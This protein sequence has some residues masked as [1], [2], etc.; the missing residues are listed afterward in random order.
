MENPFS[1]LTRYRSA[2]RK[3]GLLL[4]ALALAA[5]CALFSP[6]NGQSVQAMVKNQPFPY[7]QG[8]AMDTVLYQS[9]KAKLSAAETLKT[10]SAQTIKALQNEITAT[11]KALIDQQKLGQH[12]AKTADSLRTVL[13]D[14]GTKFKTASEGLQSAQQ[15]TDEVLKVLPRSIRKIVQNQS[16]DQQAE[17]VVDFI[18]VLKARK[19][20]W[21]GAGSG[22]AFVLTLIFAR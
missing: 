11:A 3:A 8:V 5:L 4:I 21:L 1:S 14:L 19:W 18:G 10:S 6:S 9:V 7:A 15:A 20:K 22:I 16:P 17:A 12:D 13:A 2:F